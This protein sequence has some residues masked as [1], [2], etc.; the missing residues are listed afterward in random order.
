MTALDGRSA[1]VTGAASGIG[2]ACARELAARGAKVTVADIDGAGAA[3]LA[4]EIGGKA[5]EV[6]LLDVTALEELHLDFDILV[7]NAGMQVIDAI[8]DYPPEKFRT[9][10]A[11]MVEA[12]FLLVRAVLPVMYERGFGRIINIS[13][14]HGLRASE[15]KVAYV[16]AKHALEGLSKVT[17]LEGGPHGVTSNCVNPGY[18]RTPLVTKQIADQARTHGIDEQEVLETI[19]LSE[20]AIKRLVEPDEV[21]DL[22]GW[23][24]SPAAAMV[25][26]ASYTMD[27][28]WSAR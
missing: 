26:G 14:I 1:L 19:L 27:G 9:L 3:A 18:V 8:V 7:N 15:F 13:S 21:A 4:G 10:L 23:L 16:T 28:G 11:L 12:P 6:D 5:W 2:A 17:A 24:A 25:T 22:V 20:S